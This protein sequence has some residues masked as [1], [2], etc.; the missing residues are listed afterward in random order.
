MQGITTTSLEG[1]G[2]G[3]VVVL[4]YFF[5]AILK[6][7]LVAKCFAKRLSFATCH[8]EL[9]L[10]ALQDLDLGRP[11]KTGYQADLAVQCSNCNSAQ[12][13]QLT[14]SHSTILEARMQTVLTLALMHHLLGQGG[15]NH[16]I[17]LR[18]IGGWQGETRGW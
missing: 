17:S 12:A 10:D 5:H 18:Y 16:P 8:L 7:L 2:P 6:A 15:P 1:T 11:Y 13:G 14:S 4:I 3:S 9:H